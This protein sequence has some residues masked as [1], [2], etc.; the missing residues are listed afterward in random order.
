MHGAGDVFGA[1]VKFEGQDAF[2]N[3][4]SRPGPD[5]VHPQNAIGVFVG[6]ERVLTDQQVRILNNQAIPPPAPQDLFIE[7]TRPI[8]IR[9]TDR[10]TS[11]FRKYD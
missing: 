6:D 4:V 7:F 1:G 8:Y 11:Y 5:D 10:L 9:L 2:G 3:H